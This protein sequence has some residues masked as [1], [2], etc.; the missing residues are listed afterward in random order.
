MP[1][2]DAI[3][4]LL[5]YFY[6]SKNTARKRCFLLSCHFDGVFLREERPNNR[7]HD[8]GYDKADNNQSGSAF[9]VIHKCIFAGT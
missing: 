2:R 8:D 7:N 9:Y 5:T 4:F 6:V 3:S 1:S